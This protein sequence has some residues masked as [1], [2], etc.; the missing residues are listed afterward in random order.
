MENEILKKFLGKKN[1]EFT[2]LLYNRG[3]KKLNRG[4]NIFPKY[5][6][7]CGNVL[8]T[9]FKL[10]RAVVPWE[11]QIT[12]QIWRDSRSLMLTKV[13][14]GE[15]LRSEPTILNDSVFEAFRM[16]PLSKN[17]PTKRS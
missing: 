8:F 15:L 14:P 2:G 17:I 10:F 13:F 1:T 6:V 11:R 5:L 16:G 4:G 3:N 7:F 12:Y 9:L